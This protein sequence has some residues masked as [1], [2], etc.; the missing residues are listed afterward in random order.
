MNAETGAR[1]YVPSYGRLGKIL[2]QE[3]LIGEVQLQDALR[4]QEQR[5]GKLGQILVEM[6]ALDEESL[7]GA[8][9]RQL[10]IR[11]AQIPR[12]G[13]LVGKLLERIPEG[14]ATRCR[15]VPVREEGGILA[16]AM[17]DPLDIPTLDDLRVATGLE[18]EPLL[19]TESEIQDAIER[20]YRQTGEEESGLS[21]ELLKDILQSNV[22]LQKKEE[23][24]LDLEKIRGQVEDAPVVRL[25]D[26]II[27][28][29]IRERAS[30][31]HI[32]PREDRLDIRY[33]I[34]GILHSVISPPRNLQNAIIS[35]IKILAE[36]DIAERRFPQ[37]GRFTIKLE[38]REVDLR[39]SSLPTTF[40]EKIVVRL[41]RK[42]PLSLNLEDLGF[43]A[44]SVGLFKKYIQRPYGM[45]L[46]TGPT[47]SGKTTTLYAA[48]NQ[49]TSTEKNI[50][51][52]EDPVE[53][54]LRGVYQMQANPGIG[55]TFAAGLRAILRQDPDIIMVGEVRDYETAE[56][57]V[58]AA[59]TGHLVFSTLHTNDA[60]GTIVRLVNMGIEP[61]LVCS[62]LTMSVAQR[63]VRKICTECTVPVEP[64]SDM[65]AG[66]GLDPGG[67]EILFH[68][69]KG[70]PKCKGTGYFGRTGI[71]EILEVNQRIKDLVLQGALP[72][73]IHHMAIE[74]GMI[75]LRQCAVR[76]V[77][78]GI[79]T[80]EE[81]LRVCIE[82]E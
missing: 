6:K 82:E 21:Q 33:R 7:M 1:G 12:G 72:E 20:F 11:R 62:A 37:D 8:L 38:F 58:R 59:L 63:L 16:V 73:T 44:D 10:G 32:E 29:A 9:S 14:T 47:G 3:G 53:Y 25:V 46:L 13:G 34:D 15:L 76:K 35:R 5:G 60:V 81:V 61:F 66:L 67:K 51:T 23:E 18:I 45:V 74:Q 24:K 68:R 69:G 36:M 65:V 39:V 40:G 80:F 48:L 4:R 31:I 19:A 78:A 42:G 17:A 28:N 55:L 50:V 79:T 22:E 54:Q 27:S 30:D 57:A 41:L 70:C 56:M 77:L 52:V 43:E 71:F 2:L 49:I 75:T 64:T 26:Y